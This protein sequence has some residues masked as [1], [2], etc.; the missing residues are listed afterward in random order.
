MYK[1]L[2]R[3]YNK[4]F[5]NNIWKKYFFHGAEEKIMKNNENWNK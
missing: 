2:E 4:K 3:F 5:Q 1:R